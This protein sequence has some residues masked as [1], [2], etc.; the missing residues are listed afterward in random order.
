MGYHF[1]G[2]ELKNEQKIKA[3]RKNILKPEDVCYAAEIFYGSTIIIK[4]IP[5]S[6]WVWGKVSPNDAHTAV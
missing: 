2:Y 4:N 1:T 6:A 3:R 5:L